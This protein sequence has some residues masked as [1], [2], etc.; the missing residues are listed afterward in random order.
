MGRADHAVFEDGALFVAAPVQRPDNLAGQPAGLVQD[1][2]DQVAGRL[3]VAGQG[4]DAGQAG[5][6]VEHKAHVVDRRAIVGHGK[7]RAKSGGV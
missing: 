3:L 5:N 2:I 4:G 6:M 1:G 7:P